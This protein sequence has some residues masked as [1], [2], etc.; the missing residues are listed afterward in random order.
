MLLAADVGGTKTLLG[1]FHPDDLRPRAIVQR[2]YATA[3]FPSFAA[4]LDQFAADVGTP[5]VSAAAAGVAGPVVGYSAVVTNVG[6]AVSAEEIARHLRI[7]RAA[8]LNDLAATATSIEALDASELATLQAGVPDPMGNAAVIAAGTG[9]GVAFLHRTIGGRLTAVPT[10][11]GHADFSARTDAEL[12]LVQALRAEFGRATVEHVLS[13][14]GLLNLYRL[15]HASH[16]CAATDAA[17]PATPALISQAA[18]EGSCRGCVETLAMFVEA[19]GAEAGNLALRTLATAGVY[20]GGGIAPKILPALED[21]VFMRAF[22][23][24]APMAHIVARVPV[25]VI[26]NTQAGLLGAAVAAQRIGQSA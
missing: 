19:Y 20:I 12:R 26:L 15:S 23:D 18:L 2:S 7:P 21:G 3:T 1:L 13:G 8:V 14:P 17:L 16:P 5:L 11:A 6:W 9:L 10:E 25:R 22:L 4:I 24:K